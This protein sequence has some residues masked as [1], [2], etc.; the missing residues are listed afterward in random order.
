MLRGWFPS[1]KRVVMLQMLCVSFGFNSVGMTI[2]FF[3]AN[4]K[5]TVSNRNCEI[6]QQI[7]DDGN[8]FKCS[9]FHKENT[10]HDETWQLFSIAPP[11]FASDL[12]A[13][14][15]TAPLAGERQIKGTR[16]RERQRRLRLKLH[17]PLLCFSSPGLYNFIPTYSRNRTVPTASRWTD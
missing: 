14:R 9:R 12:P 2:T 10:E 15:Q 5:P 17:L 11:G 7:S 13:I 1:N 3:Y 4:L 16:G 6:T 8:S